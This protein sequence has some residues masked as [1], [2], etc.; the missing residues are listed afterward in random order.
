MLR[1]AEPERINWRDEKEPG[2][3]EELRGREGDKL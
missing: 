2:R 3:T 1:K